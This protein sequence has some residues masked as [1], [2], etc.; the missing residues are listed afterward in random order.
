MC[1]QHEALAKL[2]LFPTTMNSPS[3]PLTPAPDSPASLTSQDTADPFTVYLA[4]TNPE[5]PPKP[6]P[7]TADNIT[8]EKYKVAVLQLFFTLVKRSIFLTLD[9]KLIES[10]NTLPCDKTNLIPTLTGFKTVAKNRDWTPDRVNCLMQFLDLIK[11]GT[12]GCKP[13]DAGD[14]DDEHVGEQIRFR[15]LLA[16]SNDSNDSND[17]DDD[18]LP[19][20]PSFAEDT[21]LDTFRAHIQD[22]FYA[23]AKLAR[24]KQGLKHKHKVTLKYCR[25]TLRVVDTNY[26]NQ[27]NYDIILK[28]SLTGKFSGTSASMIEVFQPWSEMSDDQKLELKALGPD[29]DKA[30]DMIMNEV[31]SG[32]D[33]DELAADSTLPE[34]PTISENL[35]NIGCYHAQQEL[36]PTARAFLFRATK[37]PLTPEEWEY[38]E[39]LLNL[40]DGHTASDRLVGL[41]NK[42]KRT[43][44]SSVNEMELRTMA[45]NAQ[46]D[47]EMGR[48]DFRNPQENWRPCA[49]WDLCLLPS[50]I[51]PKP[52]YHSTAKAKKNSSTPPVYKTHFGNLLTFLKRSPGQETIALGLLVTSLQPLICRSHEAQLKDRTHAIVVGVIHGSSPP[53]R[54][55]LVWDVNVLWTDPNKGQQSL[56]SQTRALLIQRARKHRKCPTFHSFW[57]NDGEK[58]NHDNICLTLTLNRILKLAQKGFKIK[59]GQDGT[60]ASIRGFLR[61][62]DHAQ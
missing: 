48:G 27:Q 45:G 29:K 55:L 31:S 5:L 11:V 35:D 44:L 30:D 60:P 21:D 6:D 10:F 1:S 46:P 50:Q 32:E 16:D 52:L 61:V 56:H 47:E 28:H 37:H 24:N 36:V 58:R 13:E 17:S 25:A 33:E 8:I 7:A 18:D 42:A 12:Y 26:R 34:V 59:W 9:E 15:I 57:I 2:L 23:L 22:R 43:T 53:S 19:V 62:D 14:T 49:E 20:V 51:E 54:A 38:F 4:T 3:S 41:F 40:L 39:Q